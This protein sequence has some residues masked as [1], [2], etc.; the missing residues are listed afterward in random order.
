MLSTLKANL[1]YH[2]NHDSD[3]NAFLESIDIKKI[4]IAMVS[5]QSF[6][7][8]SRGRADL[9]ID[10]YLPLTRIV[11]RILYFDHPNN[12]LLREYRDLSSRDRVA[13]A[14]LENQWESRENFYEKHFLFSPA[15]VIINFYHKIEKIIGHVN[16]GNYCHMIEDVLSMHIKDILNNILENSGDIYSD[17][18]ELRH[19]F[20]DFEY[21]IPLNKLSDCT[22][23]AIHG[24]RNEKTFALRNAINSVVPDDLLV[25]D[26]YAFDIKEL[27]L[28]TDDHFFVNPYTKR[29]YTENSRAMLKAHPKL[30]ARAD[31]VEGN[32]LP[33][34]PTPTPT[35]TPP[36]SCL[37]QEMIRVISDFRN[38]LK[39]AALQKKDGLKMEKDALSIINEFNAWRNFLSPKDKKNLDDQSICINVT[40]YRFKEFFEKLCNQEIDIYSVGNVL[41]DFVDKI[42]WSNKIHQLCYITVPNMPQGFQFIPTEN[43]KSGDQKKDKQYQVRKKAKRGRY[44]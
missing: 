39:R 4:I 36:T 25:L 1:K 32:L 38:H 31:S 11:D 9:Q 5:I 44:F 24:Y 12:R 26:G 35:P 3:F 30:Q 18:V 8:C 15:S 23:F 19:G 27:N 21:R 43:R 7:D 10:L 41:D 42:E 29:Q 17:F 28:L 37:S 14:D 2:M 22:R 33:P 13:F 6:T 20:F 16:F 40:T 34:T